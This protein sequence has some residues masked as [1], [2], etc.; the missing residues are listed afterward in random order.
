LNRHGPVI[1]AGCCAIGMAALYAGAADGSPR[2]RR[3]QWTAYQIR[4]AVLTTISAPRWAP[5]SAEF[6]IA[7]A[8]IRP[9]HLK[10]ARMAYP[11]S[12]YGWL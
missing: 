6:T 10:I 3:A 7:H 4:P 5:A 9:V 2:L 11:V 1:S 12:R 8:R